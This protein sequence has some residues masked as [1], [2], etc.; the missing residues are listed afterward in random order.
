MT[1]VLSSSNVLLYSQRLRLIRSIRKLGDL[2]TESSQ[3]VEV[4]PPLPQHSP[5]SFMNETG[6][7]ALLT[8]SPSSPQARSFLSLRLPKS[9]SGDRS[10]LSP[11]FTVS[12]HSPSTPVIDPET[13][14]ERKL[15]KV[16]QTLGE[17]VPP[18]LVFPAPARG[19]GRNR[20]STMSVP[21]YS[22][23]DKCLVVATGAAVVGRRRHAREASC[24]VLK[25]AASSTSLR[26]PSRPTEVEPFSYPSLVPFEE[27]GAHTSHILSTAEMGSEEPA[28]KAGAMRRKE[29]GWSG[30]WSGSV[31]NMDDVVRGLRGLRLK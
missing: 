25:H 30:E 9:L 17:N 29:V 10:P 6:S 16:A 23:A 7:P 19:K 13:L 27:S 2:L 21:E 1:S 5:E 14:K 22:A 12:L 11:T 31:H 20:A 28:R 18:E 15:A 26:A 3:L 8:P 4:A 24:A